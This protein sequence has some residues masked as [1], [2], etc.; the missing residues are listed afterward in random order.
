MA[1]IESEF[2]GEAW[3]AEGTR[4]GFV[5]LHGVGGLQRA[6]ALE[7]AALRDA[8]RELGDDV[9]F[10]LGDRDLA[11]H[12]ERT[13]RLK[14][15]ETLSAVTADLCK[16]M[17]VGPAIVPMTDDKVRTR[18]LTDRGWLDFQDYFVRRRCGPS[19]REIA[20]AGAPDARAHP[21]F[22]AA[23]GS[24]RLRAVVICPSNPFISIGPILALPGM[25]AALAASPAL[26][27]AVTPLVGGQALKG[28]TVEMLRGLGMPA[29]P[30]S[31]RLV[32][33]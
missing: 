16:R 24:E 12:V 32:T 30:S 33:V 6:V 27:V 19:V 21:A 7:V 29:E 3:A 5:H 8:L 11:L 10:N 9:W 23:L 28:P 18:L 20:F 2:L 25:R 22:L 26:R 1:G 17:G 14:S 4:V 15:G 31:A 13:R